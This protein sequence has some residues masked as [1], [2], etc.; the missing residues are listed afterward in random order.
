MSLVAGIVELHFPR[1]LG[2]I[3]PHFQEGATP[4]PYRSRVTSG[5]LVSEN[6]FLKLAA[7]FS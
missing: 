7:G 2:A 1:L 5:L 3:K 6:E 4:P